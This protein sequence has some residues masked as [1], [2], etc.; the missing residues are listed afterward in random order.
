MENIIISNPDELNQKIEIIKS[1]GI[2]N[3]HVVSDFDRTLTKCFVNGEKHST[4]FSILVKGSFA[5]EENN[6]KY[7]GLFEKY[8]PF[9][10]G[11]Y[12]M[13]FK[14]KKMQEWWSKY[15]NIMIESGLNKEIA[16]KLS[17]EV[18]C[19]LREKT[20]EMLNL[21]HED[22]IPLLIFSAGMGDFITK[23]MNSG[24]NNFDNIHIISNFMDFEED[25]SLKGFKNNIVHVFNKS[26]VQLKSSPYLEEIKERK[27][28]ILLGDSLGDLG[29]ISGIE[30]DNV[31]KI[32]FLNENVE[33]LIDTYKKEFDV[34]ITDDGSMEYALSLI[35]GLK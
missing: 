26:E 16:E 32:G 23:I 34:V 10:I 4:S 19:E 20:S 11:N 28:V 13:D 35:K 6:K 25:G 29:M 2:D 21:L 15:M 31:I 3:L 12:P 7:Y 8:Y 24:D 17:E 30:H 33:E 22:K 18:I 1:D 27:N 5:T 14:I 9:E